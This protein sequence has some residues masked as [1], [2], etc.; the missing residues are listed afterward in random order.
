MSYKEE[1]EKRRLAR[2][3]VEGQD[4]AKR[5]AQRA[6][7]E[8]RA[9]DLLQHFSDQKIHEVGLAIEDKSSEG[10]VLLHAGSPEF[11]RID[12]DAAHYLVA[13]Y[14]EG[15]PVAR[16]IKG[17]KRLRSFKDIDEYI[18]EFLESIRS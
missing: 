4:M 6:K 10:T 1:M 14:I 16:P 13:T 5:Q 18:F 11:V 9:K 15:V 7:L 17:A 3:S 12:V 8:S 2:Q